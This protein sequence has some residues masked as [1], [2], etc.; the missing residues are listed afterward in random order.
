MLLIPPHGSHTI[1]TQQQHLGLHSAQY[2]ALEA[3]ESPGMVG[4]LGSAQLDPTPKLSL[5]LLNGPKFRG[6]G[7]MA[8]LLVLMVGQPSKCCHF[9]NI[10]F[11]D[12]F[13]NAEK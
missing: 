1:A 6:G 11:M 5:L 13:C 9:H 3:G 7:G 2:G 8:T 10:T 12:I 4:P